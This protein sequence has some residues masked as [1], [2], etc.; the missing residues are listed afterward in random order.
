MNYY[1][2]ERGARSQFVYFGCIY[3]IYNYYIVL[4]QIYKYLIGTLHLSLSYNTFS[5]LG[6]FSKYFHYLRLEGNTR[7]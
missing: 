2:S 3:Y 5:I 4:V 1:T 7:D 6:N